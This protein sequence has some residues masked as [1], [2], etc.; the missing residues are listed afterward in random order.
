M[1]HQSF[2]YY[3]A[4]RDN[5]INHSPMAGQDVTLAR[6]CTNSPLSQ[7][8]EDM[9]LCV[10]CRKRWLAQWTNEWQDES[11][12][13]H[14]TLGMC[15]Y[16]GWWKVRNKRNL[17]YIPGYDASNFL[18]YSNQTLWVF[19]ILESYNIKSNTAPLEEVQR[20][21]VEDWRFARE[22][23]PKIAQD[24]VMQV[25]KAHM[26]CEVFYYDDAVYAPDGGID[27]VLVCSDRTPIAFQVKRR[28]VEKSEP[29]QPIREFVGAVAKSPFHEGIYV[30]TANLSRYAKKELDHSTSNLVDKGMEISLVD[31]EI[32]RELMRFHMPSDR[33]LEALS[34]DV[35]IHGWQNYHL[36]ITNVSLNELI[37]ITKNSQIK[38]SK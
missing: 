14:Y 30:T 21:L 19:A 1:N 9:A 28:E 3:R 25:F 18:S 5:W 35:P 4:S 23:S 38:V 10:M 15:P 7:S 8:E 37:N 29:I 17:T 20:V 31:G 24:M 22:I 36:G 32:L 34:K 16:C 2:Y 13:L 6:D 11:R 12:D 26:N 33:S 27:F